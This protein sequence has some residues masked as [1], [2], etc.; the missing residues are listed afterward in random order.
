MSI[1]IFA[2]IC[3][4]LVICVSVKNFFIQ[5]VALKLFIDSLIFAFITFR[6][7]NQDSIVSQASAW[8]LS[9]FATSVIFI[10]MAVSVRRYAVLKKSGENV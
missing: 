5:L 4:S 8:L 1:L 6:M 2:M 7:P 3:L 10:L 9:A